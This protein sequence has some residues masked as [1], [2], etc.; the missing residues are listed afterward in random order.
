MPGGEQDDFDNAQNLLAEGIIDLTKAK[1]A[2]ERKRK[3]PSLLLY[4]FTFLVLVLWSSS[5]IWSPKES[6]FLLAPCLIRPYIP[7]ME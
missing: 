3:V 4:K 7:M 5:R 1:E 6:F 2:A